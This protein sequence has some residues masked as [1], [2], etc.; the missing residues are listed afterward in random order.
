[1]PRS[2][3]IPSPN[4]GPFLNDEHFANSTFKAEEIFHPKTLEL[5]KNDKIFVFKEQYSS[6]YGLCFVI[7]KLTPEK[8]SDYSTQ[9]VVNN[10][11]DYNYYLHESFENE[12]LLM[13]VYPYE[14][15]I[16]RMNAENN[17]DIGGASIQNSKE[18]I[19]KIVGNDGCDERS[20][21]P[22]HVKLNKKK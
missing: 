18:I 16:N 15:V 17:D 6:Y 19:Q 7:Q 14:V 4:S 8:I 5:F 20:L 2:Q 9:L 22:D 21:G 13:N 12:W 11:M 1:M 10:A 3:L